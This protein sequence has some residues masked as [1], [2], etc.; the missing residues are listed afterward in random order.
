MEYF[1]ITIISLLIGYFL[2]QGKI[3]RETIT[4]V[5]SQAKKKLDTSPVGAIHR[6]TARD[7]YLK[8]HPLEKEGME[9]IAEDLRKQGIPP[10]EIL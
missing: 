7:I 10:N 8:E 3:T 2:G 5:L 9:A 6:P 1:V 4:Q